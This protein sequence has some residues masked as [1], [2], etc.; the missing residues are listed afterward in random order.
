MPGVR[1]FNTRPLYQ[2]VADEFAS[3]LIRGEWSPGQTIANEAHIARSLGISVGTARK[4][5][6]ILVDLGLLERYQGRGTVVPDAERGERRN[7][8]SNIR[9]RLGGRICGDIEVDAVE[10]LTPTPV[11]AAQLGINERTPV[12][13]FARKRRYRDRLFMIENVFLRVDASFREGDRDQLQTAAVRRWSG[14]D[15][16]TTKSERAFPCQVDAGEAKAFG[17]GK[18]ELALCLERVIHSYQARPLELRFARCVLGDDL[19][20]TAE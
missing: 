18:G 12:L 14:Y 10:M 7:R 4:A 2:Q 17:V 13:S 20:Y 8:F 6:D 5:F 19:V 15:I 1:A 3:R 16:A 11:I 9:D